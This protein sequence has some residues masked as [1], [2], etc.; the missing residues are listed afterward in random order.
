MENQISENLTD[1][2]IKLATIDTCILGIQ[3][4]IHEIRIDL[5]EV[6]E[7]TDDFHLFIKNTEQN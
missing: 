4:I 2:Y 6:I 3:Q 7:N 1:I 5:G